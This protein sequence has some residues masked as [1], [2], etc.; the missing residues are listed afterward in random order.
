M[1]KILLTAITLL[2]VTAMHAQNGLTL[3]PNPDWDYTWAECLSADGRYVGGTNYNE[4]NAFVYD[5]QTN[6]LKVFDLEDEDFGAEVRGISNNGIGAGYDGPAKTF[7]IDGTVT[8]FGTDAFLSGITPDGKIV[9][10]SFYNDYDG[11]SAAYWDA[12][13]TRHDL[14]EPSDLR[15]GNEIYGTQANWI[16]ADSSIIVGYV[17][18]D[19]SLWPPMV[20][21]RNRDNQTYSAVVMYKD[22]FDWDT[23]TGKPYSFFQPSG[24]SENGKW[25]ALTL[26]T[27][28]ETPC[29]GFARYNFETESL[30]VF[31]CDENSGDFAEFTE[32]YA[33]SIANDGTL[34]G[35]TAYSE[36]RQ[37]FIWEGG[38]KTPELLRTK[39]ATIEE[40][41][42]F[43]NGGFHSPCGISADGRYICGSAITY[44]D[45][46]DFTMT[47][48]VLD[49]ENIATGITTVATSKISA[50]AAARYFSIDGKRLT[51]KTRGLNIV[52]RADGRTL[53]VVNR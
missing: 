52:K 49:R 5:T 6:T 53:K 1:K 46:D 18:D 33:Q 40:F 32:P 43:D 19:F 7:N 20:W 16:S 44:N 21:R 3:L 26:T 27:N 24:L 38:S 25:M 22:Y 37:G 36:G 47:S 42:D 45:N 13:G 48:Y 14:P 41:V 8:S 17:Q 10:G 51:G 39:Y 28:S 9:V 50:D 12:S 2:A 35:F 34:V 15:A 29:G 30:E 23:S 4:M 11:V 31:L